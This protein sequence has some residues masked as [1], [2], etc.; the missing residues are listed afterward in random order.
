MKRKIIDCEK[1]VGCK[2]CELACMVVHSPD[3]N[4]HQAYREGGMG[5]VRA[6]CKIEL[7]SGGRL[8]PEHCRHCREA[9]CL[10]ACMSGALSR[11]EQD[12]VVCDAETCVGCFMCVMS[13]PFGAA[14]PATSGDRVMVKCDGCSDRT[15]PACVETCPTACLTL[16]EEAGQDDGVVYVNPPQPREAC[17]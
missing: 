13:C 8:F 15:F 17:G 2:N 9:Q 16:G 7:T 10:Q 6:R 11:N 4:L 12:F 14:R 1:C 5:A 3:E